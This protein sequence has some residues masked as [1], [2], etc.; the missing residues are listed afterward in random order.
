MPL[1]R[2]RPTV[3]GL[4][5]LIIATGLASAEERVARWQSTELPVY[6][7]GRTAVSGNVVAPTPYDCRLEN[8]FPFRGTQPTPDSSFTVFTA[9]EVT[10][11]LVQ[12]DIA[13]DLLRNADARHDAAVAALGADVMKA[14]NGAIARMEGQ[15][16]TPMAREQM[17]TEV[18]ARLGP[19]LE[20][21]VREVRGDVARLEER[22]ALLEARL[23]S[24]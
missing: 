14:V 24:R 9:V 4:A 19:V 12:R 18:A 3:F 2:L 8:C 16:L 6:A 17:S 20:E 10:A 5:I 22:L 21:R 7:S 11:Q 1:G 23:G 15:P 13:I